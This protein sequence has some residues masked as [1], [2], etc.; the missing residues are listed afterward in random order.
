M[1]GV[2]REPALLHE[3]VNDLGAVVVVREDGEIDTELE[4]PSALFENERL[5]HARKATRECVDAHVS[6]SRVRRASARAA[7]G[8]ERASRVT[9]KGSARPVGGRSV[10]P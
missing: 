7:R 2:P 6:P 3:W 4:K 5:R 8:A 10:R 9:A 1:T